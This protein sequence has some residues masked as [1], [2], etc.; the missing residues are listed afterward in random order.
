MVHAMPAECEVESDICVCIRDCNELLSN[1]INELLRSVE[2]WEGTVIN[3]VR[4][5]RS[6]KHGGQKGEEEAVRRS[7]E[8]A[9]PHMDPAAARRGAREDSPADGLASKQEGNG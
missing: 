5:F 3:P 2:L 4:G 1:R 8:R 9:P 7:Q 6:G